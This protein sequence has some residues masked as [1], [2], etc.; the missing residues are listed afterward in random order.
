M[1]GHVDKYSWVDIGSSFLPGE[2]SAGFLR[3]QMEQAWAITARRLALWDAYHEVFEAMESDGVCRRPVIPAD[4]THNAHLYYLLLPDAGRRERF[5]RA[6]AG[7]GIGAIFHY[8]PLHSSEAGRRFARAHGS[9]AT[10]ERVASTLVRLPLY[11]GL[12]DDQARVVDTAR[13]LLYG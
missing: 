12:E 8:V 1:E 11:L 4:C 7:A 6:M 13:R 3:A 9:L 2:I 5:I 10:T